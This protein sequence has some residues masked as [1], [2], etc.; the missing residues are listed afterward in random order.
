MGSSE[1]PVPRDPSCPG[2]DDPAPTF[3]AVDN[4]DERRGLLEPPLLLRPGGHLVFS[5]F[6]TLFG[7]GT[8]QEEVGAAG[9]ES[10][11]PGLSGGWVLGPRTLPVKR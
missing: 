6:P 1:D 9:V 11:S 4:V 3:V 8:P 10:V 2:T 5:F 7:P